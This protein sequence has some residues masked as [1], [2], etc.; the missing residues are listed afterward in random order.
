M[1]K[2]LKEKEKNSQKELLSK[3]LDNSNAWSND[4]G[5][6]LEEMKQMALYSPVLVSISIFSTALS[7]SKNPHTLIHTP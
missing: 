7:W 5:K 4:L 2:D 3:A 6:T 1:I